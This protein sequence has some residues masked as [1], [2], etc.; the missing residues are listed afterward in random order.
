[1]FSSTH[2]FYLN[3]KQLTPQTLSTHLLI[4]VSC[5]SLIGLFVPT[6]NHAVCEIHESD[7]LKLGRSCMLT[8]YFRLKENEKSSKTHKIPT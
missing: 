8:Q 1:M 2:A 6:T 7:Y 3:L 4:T 5:T